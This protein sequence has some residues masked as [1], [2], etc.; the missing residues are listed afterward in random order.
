MASEI[1]V[2][3]TIGKV[4]KR[5]VGSYMVTYSTISNGCPRETKITCTLSNWEDKALP[6]KGQQVILSD[7]R[8]FKNEWR[9][10]R[11]RPIKFPEGKER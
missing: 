4:I 8:K 5:K 2:E 6:E 3:S 1:E 11:A 7:L 10:L 9:A